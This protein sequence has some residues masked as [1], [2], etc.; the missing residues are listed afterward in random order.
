MNL[1][2]ISEISM[3]V[4]DYL[5][6]IFLIREPALPGT[7]ELRMLRSRIAVKHRP[8]AG[9]WALP[10]TG[11]P[12]PAVASWAPR[13]SPAPAL[14]RGS[15][16]GTTTALVWLVA[17]ARGKDWSCALHRYTTA[18]SKRAFQDLDPSPGQPAFR[19]ADEWSND[20]RVFYPARGH[21]HASTLAERDALDLTLRA[22]LD[23]QHPSASDASD[24]EFRRE[25]DEIVVGLFG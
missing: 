3:Q 19:I 9:N 7:A 6:E 12:T 1:I 14:R 10:S 13:R 5:T 17:P 8:L 16:P 25:T 21:A 23:E 24:C 22:V 4:Y 20:V 11:S 2:A 15:P 18:G